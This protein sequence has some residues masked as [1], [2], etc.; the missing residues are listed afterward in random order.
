MK[1]RVLSYILAVVMVLCTC[2]T[3]LC[4]SAGDYLPGLI[5][6]YQELGN[7]SS[8]ANATCSESSVKIN[9]GG[10]VKYEFILPFD[11]ATLDITYSASASTTLTLKTPRNSYTAS[12]SAGSTTYQLTLTPEHMGV[13]SMEISS[14]AAV[15]ISQLK[16]T[17]IKEPCSDDETFDSV[18]E[19]TDYQELL[20]T[21]IVISEK[22]SAIKV[23][24]LTRY[25]NFEDT[26]ETTTLI[27]GKMYL[28]IGT[29]ARAFS[30]Y[31]EDYT[32]LMYAYISGEDFAIYLKPGDS[33]YESRGIKSSFED[34][35]IYKNGITYVPVR[36]LAEMLGYTVYYRDGLAVIDNKIAANEILNNYDVFEELKAE[37]MAYEPKPAEY[38]I[39]Y[40][41]SKEDI[42]SDGNT[43]REEAPF[44]TIQKAADVA[45]AGDTVIIHEGVYNEKVTVKNSGTASK[46]IIFKAADGEDVT[47]SAFKTVSG[48]VPYTNPANN[49]SMYVTDV[50]HLLFECA[51]PGAWDVDRNF[52]LYNDD[53]LVEGRH[54]NGKTSTARTVTR[55]NET[56]DATSNPD[57]TESFTYVATPDHNPS[58]PDINNHK[59]LPTQGDMRIRDVLA[60]G[61]I[62]R[63]DHT[64]YSEIDLNQDT[65]DYW[66]GATYLGRVGMAWNMSAG[67]VTA[68]KKNEATVSE[69]WITDIPVGT[70]TYYQDKEAEDYGFLTHHLNTVDRPGE[71]YIDMETKKMY[72]IP[73]SGANPETMEFEVKERQVLFDMRG[74]EYVQLHNVNTRGGGITM[75]ECLGC[76]L[77]GGTHKY[78]SQFDLSASHCLQ[79][80]STIYA[81]YDTLIDDYKF[82]NDGKY[83]MKTN[84]L[85]ETGIVVSGHYN[86]VVNTDIEYSASS[87]IDVMG[88]YNYVENNYVSKTAYGVTYRSGIHLGGGYVEDGFPAGG[89]QAYQNTVIGTGRQAMGGGGVDFAPMDIAFNDL[90]WANTIAT[91]SGVFYLYGTVGGTD[92]TKSTIHHNMMHDNVTSDIGSAMQTVFYSDGNTALYD[93]YNN[94]FYLSSDDPNYIKEDGHSGYAAL[95]FWHGD[96]SP[97]VIQTHWGNTQ[98]IFESPDKVKFDV[99]DYPNGYPFYAGAIRDENPRFMMNYERDR[100]E[101]VINLGNVGLNWGSYL[102]DDNMVIFPNQSSTVRADNVTLGDKGTKIDLYYS[103]D[104]YTK[105]MASLPDMNFEFIDSSNQTVGTITKQLKRFAD[106]ADVL[107]HITVY[108]PAKYKDCTSIRISTS[109]RDIGFAKMILT[110]FDMEAENAK[111]DIPY[112]AD[113]ILMGSANYLK[114]STGHTAIAPTTSKEIFNVDMDRYLGLGNTYN[115]GARYDNRK[116]SD[117]CTKVSLEAITN[118]ASSGTKATVYLGT[119]TWGEKIAE[120]NYRPTFKEGDMWRPKT[121]TADLLRPLAPGTYTIFVQWASGGTSEVTKMYFY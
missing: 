38:P 56:L 20:K 105:N 69:K 71:W 112:D 62:K 114:V 85:G 40:H 72:V 97:S 35:A 95:E 91:D 13:T 55:K 108:V 14:S 75:A 80:L 53:V 27:D 83:F 1:K 66:K 47:L 93:V 65:E 59:L 43:G 36:E 25:I 16:Y 23:R 32:D 34:I 79:S 63:Y 120:I 84:L 48:F 61:T 57:Q 42:A 121:L 54:P 39:V 77:D 21:A 89:H 111:V 119:G 117:T 107:S 50:S 74:K 100:D 110:D 41:V 17:K 106:Y 3:F 98:K 8:S 52:V 104:Y 7:P 6:Y 33:Y 94:V 19:Y 73:P 44:A 101:S 5:E 109:S 113:M 58:Y 29:F 99:S 26:K 64:L 28:P 118:Y 46:P 102:N 12:L 31:Y 86:A 24:N 4:V 11:A 70:I 103:G 92:L 115:H 60:K 45:R 87:G 22:S 81:R 76:V 37:L 67:L 15:T 2:N 90:G 9:A 68:S 51:L 49:V 116:I 82:G 88:S 18:V 10:N 78:I 96:N 30:L